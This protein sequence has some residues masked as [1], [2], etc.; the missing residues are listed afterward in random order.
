[1]MIIMIFSY[2]VSLH[3]LVFFFPYV[4]FFSLMT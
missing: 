3:G 1:M 2:D 4:V